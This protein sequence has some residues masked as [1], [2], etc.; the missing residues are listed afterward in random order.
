MDLC[1]DELMH[2]TAEG[3][4]DIR[5]YSS[6]YKFCKELIEWNFRETGILKADNA[7]HNKVY[8]YIYIYI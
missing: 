6:N 8:K 1:S 3:H 7:R 2:I 4:A 5:K